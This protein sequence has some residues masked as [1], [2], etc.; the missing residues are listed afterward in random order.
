MMTRHVTSGAVTASK[1]VPHNGA[2]RTVQIVVRLYVD[3]PAKV[4]EYIE[5]NSNV[6]RERYHYRINAQ[7]INN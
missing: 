5:Y 4:T 1:L 3:I 7:T 6:S 2:C